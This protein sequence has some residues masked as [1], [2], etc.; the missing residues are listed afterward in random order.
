MKKS[1]KKI[2]PQNILGLVVL[3]VGL[4]III[5]II[6]SF[7]FQK[8]YYEVASRVE[9]VK[10]ATNA[11]NYE[12][13][14][15]IKVQGTKID[16]PVIYTENVNELRN[17]VESFSW[18]LN[19]PKSLPDRTVLFGHNMRNI[20][21]KPLIA[22]SEHERFEQLA[23]FVYYDFAKENK[24]IQYTF[25]GKDYLYK[26]YSVSIEDI[27]TD[28]LSEEKT[29]DYLQ[30]YIKNALKNSFYNYQVDVN[31]NDKLLTLSTCTKV[32]PDLETHSLRIDA[33]LVRDNEKINDYEVVK[34]DT[35][36]EI[37]EILGVGGKENESKA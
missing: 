7:I 18:I 13:V 10:T 5:L 1:K 20:S 23:S 12:T 24:Y 17:I 11:N 36:K 37:E 2:V 4:I 31:E 22:D 33:R 29:K 19:K 26:I 28:Y 8:D 3:L 16:Y 6:S 21:S 9:N 35:Y 27:E 14:G 30:K 34:N 25:N 15:W 32:N